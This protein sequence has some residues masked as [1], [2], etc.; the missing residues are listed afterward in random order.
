M[1]GIIQRIRPKEELVVAFAQNF[2]EPD[3]LFFQ[4]F[5]ERLACEDRNE[6][7]TLWY[8]LVCR[9]LKAVRVRDWSEVRRAVFA[10]AAAIDVKLGAELTGNE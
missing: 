4:L 9:A 3:W 6:R 7:D 1:S 2:N 10:A 5:A 8:A